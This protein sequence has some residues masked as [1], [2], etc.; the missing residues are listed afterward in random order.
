[1]LAPKEYENHILHWREHTRAVQE[2]SFKYQTPPEA[3]ERLIDHIMAT[4][5]LMIDQAA[6][7]PTFQ[8]ELAKLPLFPMFFKSVPPAQAPAPM[9]EQ[10]M[11]PGQDAMGAPI[12][13]VPGMP[14]N[15]ALGGEQ[16]ALNQEPMPPVEAQL[17]PGGPIQPTGG[18]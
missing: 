1:M 2:Y 12:Q 4:E 7:N 6:A 17:Q 3:Q 15:P 5:M 16:Q 9:A 14:V 13:S 11:M 10:P 18:A 8:A